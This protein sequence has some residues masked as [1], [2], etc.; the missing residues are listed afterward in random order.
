VVAAD[1]LA[2]RVKEFATEIATKRPAYALALSK[3]QVD[4][5]VSVDDPEVM[6][7]LEAYS[8]AQIQRGHDYYEGEQAF[9]DKREP[10]FEGY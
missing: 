4:K 6:G 8:L 5:G 10:Q 9:V 7:M 3:L 2:K 1:L